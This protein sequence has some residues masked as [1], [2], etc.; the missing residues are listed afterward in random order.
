DDR[1][2]AADDRPPPVVA[3]K[4]EGDDGPDTKKEDG[5]DRDPAPPKGDGKTNSEPPLQKGEEKV[6]RGQPKELNV[7]EERVALARVQARTYLVRYDEKAKRTVVYVRRGEG[8]MS[9]PGNWGKTGGLPFRQGDKG[10]KDVKGL[11]LGDAPADEGKDLVAVP[12][13]KV[14]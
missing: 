5:M 1:R 6:A 9:A 3:G 7:E 13:E 11:D 4:G 14:D 12:L 8:K 2:R 10:L